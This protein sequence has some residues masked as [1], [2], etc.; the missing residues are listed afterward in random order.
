MQRRAAV[1]V[2]AATVPRWSATAASTDVFGLGEGPLWDAPR[3]RVLWVDIE[4]GT[5]HAGELTA[6]QVLRRRSWQ[7]DRTVGAV[8]CSA[9]G[10]LLVAGAR[11][12]ITVTE[13][14]QVT[15]PAIIREPTRRLNDGGCDPAGNFLVGT[16]ALDGRRGHETL[17]RIER[18]QTVTVLDQDLTLSNGLAWSAEGT[19]LYSVDS[20]PGTI[21]IRSYDAATGTTGPRREWLRVTDGVPDGICMD[22]EGYLWVAIW[23]AGQV[24]RYAPDGQLAGIVDVPAP[25]TSSV[26]FVGDGRDQLLITT[27][28]VDLAA[29]QL[30]AF[31]DSGRLFLADVGVSGL[32]VT[33]WSGG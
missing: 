12:L 1:S 31:P 22:A 29:K 33:S 19:L 32:P 3:R 16:L 8:V 24:H 14:G 17:V 7:L 27:A 10:D 25:N 11:A 15:G 2:S 13:A 30:A 26:A 5:V 6:G 20:V 18:D 4:A 28:A 9:A 23:G 21:W